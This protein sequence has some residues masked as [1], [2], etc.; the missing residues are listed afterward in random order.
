MHSYRSGIA[1]LDVS[2][3]EYWFDTCILVHTYWL[4]VL[5]LQFFQALFQWLYS[6]AQ[7]KTESNELY[8]FVLQFAPDLIIIYLHGIYENKTQVRE[9]G[10]I[11][12]TY[13]T[14]NYSRAYTSVF[15]PEILWGWGGAQNWLLKFL[16]GWWLLPHF[17]TTWM[18]SCTYMIVQA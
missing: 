10:Y 1:Y 11:F 13:I 16:Q 8:N 12:I 18:K 7:L 5:F 6:C 15:H 17:A 14:F 4:L 2:K 3:S 9:R